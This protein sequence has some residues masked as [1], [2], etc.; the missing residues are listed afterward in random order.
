MNT[1]PAAFELQHCNVPQPHLL[2]EDPVT[3]KWP[4]PAPR[5]WDEPVPKARKSLWQR[6]QD[7]LD[8]VFFGEFD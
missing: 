5:A 3:D 1:D 2:D 4:L 7:W 8:D 6:W